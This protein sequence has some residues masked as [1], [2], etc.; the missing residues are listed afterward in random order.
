[1]LPPEVH[2]EDW[3]FDSY[4]FMNLFWNFASVSSA[5]RIG[6][7]IN[8]KAKTTAEHII[9]DFVFKGILLSISQEY[10]HF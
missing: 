8:A 6:D 5:I 4:C 7:R 3:D 9:I 1:M 2:C 10:K